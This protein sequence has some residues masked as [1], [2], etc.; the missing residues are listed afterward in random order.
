MQVETAV[1]SFKHQSQGNWEKR[2]LGVFIVLTAE[3]IKAKGKMF[4]TSGPAGKTSG[5]VS[6][7][8]G[9][10]VVTHSSSFSAQFVFR[11]RF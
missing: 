3:S 8:A 1:R 2:A 11:E 4:A 6:V 9:R 7:S 5:R 10:H